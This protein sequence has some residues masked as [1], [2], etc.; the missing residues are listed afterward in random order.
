ML[1]LVDVHLPLV[2]LRT[3][4]TLLG[5]SVRLSSSLQL[6]KPTQTAFLVGLPSL[7]RVTDWQVLGQEVTGG[8]G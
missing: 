5:E 4:C 6:Q 7:V 2:V 1:L 8:K 3:M